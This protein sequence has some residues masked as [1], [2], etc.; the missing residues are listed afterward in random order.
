VNGLR[1]RALLRAHEASPVPGRRMLVAQCF[2]A[3]YMNQLPGGVAGDLVRAH[4]VRGCVDGTA[5]SM[6]V[7]LLERVCGLVA[8]ALLAA[9]GMIGIPA[10]A[11]GPFGALLEVFALAT[12]AVLALGLCAPLVLGRSRRLGALVGRLPVVGPILQRLRAPSRLRPMIEAVALS[13]LIHVITVT[14]IATFV[15]EIAPASTLRVVLAVTPIAMLVTFIPLTPAGFGQ[16]EAAFV[17]LYRLAGVGANEAVAA[18][19][20][21]FAASTLSIGV[22][23]VLGAVE[24]LRGRALLR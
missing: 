16:R 21:W 3:L 24:R 12:G 4:T 13:F 9:V 1:W 8:L 6:A 22:G 23:L 20:L 18:S 15:T 17:E 7:L 2:I 5:T 19:L 14:V 11:G 10:L